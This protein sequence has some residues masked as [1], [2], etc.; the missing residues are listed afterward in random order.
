LE[1]VEIDC[2][3]LEHLHLTSNK[4]TELDLSK[5]PNLKNLVVND[6]KLTKLEAKHLKN[7]E[8]LNCSKNK[9]NELDV[10]G[11][12]KL[13][14]LNCSSE[15][16]IFEFVMA[17]EI[18]AAAEG[19]PELS[20]VGCNNLKVI[21]TDMN[22]LIPSSLDFAH[23]KNLEAISVRNNGYRAHFRQNNPTI[24]YSLRMEPND[25]NILKLN[26]PHLTL[27]DTKNSNI[28]GITNQGM[29]YDFQNREP[30]LA[31]L[32]NP[33]KFTIITNQTDE[34]S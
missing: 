19:M 21:D 26:S 17:D 6:N 29:T 30:F 11:L 18:S 4:L 31:T 2:P 13:E 32:N 28:G 23:L 22:I 27:V 15:F 24:P 10:G 20:T 7:L 1:E 34:T 16:R 14:D 3:S 25:E 33:D 8:T 9:L 5:T 12:E